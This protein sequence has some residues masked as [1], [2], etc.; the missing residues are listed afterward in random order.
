MA[1]L[2]VREKLSGIGKCPEMSRNVQKCSENN[3]NNNNNNKAQR[4]NRTSEKHRKY[5][6]GTRR[7][8]NWV[9]V[10]VSLD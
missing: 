6:F 1:T 9:G 10:I 8:K 3:N 4:K 2:K 5:L 7:K